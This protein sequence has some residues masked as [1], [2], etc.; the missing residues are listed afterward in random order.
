MTDAANDAIK[1]IVSKDVTLTGEIALDSAVFINVDFK[2]ARLIY[3]GG[4]P[5]SFKNCRFNNAT[6]IFDGPAGNTLAF[7]NAMAPVATGMRHF[8][9]GLLPAMKP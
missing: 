1:G 2:S 4:P 5:P 6:F 3:L 9:M 8:A 7:V